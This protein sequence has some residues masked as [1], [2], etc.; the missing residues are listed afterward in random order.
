MRRE[1]RSTII[2]AQI[3][4]IRGPWSSIVGGRIVAFSFPDQLHKS[5][6]NIGNRVRAYIF[7]ASL[8]VLYSYGDYVAA[9][10]RIIGIPCKRD[11]NT[12]PVDA[13]AALRIGMVWEI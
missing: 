7:I 10:I 8:V 5:G 3:I 13:I 6:I 2:V 4:F 1:R 11:R 12:I 9:F